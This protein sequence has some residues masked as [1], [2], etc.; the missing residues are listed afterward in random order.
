V[1]RFSISAEEREQIFYT[2]LIKA[3]VDFQK[4]AKAAKVLAL[5]PLD[6]QLTRED[7]QLVKDACYQWLA[8]RKRMNFISQ[9]INKFHTE[10]AN[11]PVNSIK[12]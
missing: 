12:G 1:K 4:A 7:E 10:N 11:Y 9:V 2:E 8:Q 5:D 3:G 6:E